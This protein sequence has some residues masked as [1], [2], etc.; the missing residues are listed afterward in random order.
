MSDRDHLGGGQ[1]RF[2]QPDYRIRASLLI[3]PLLASLVLGGPQIRAVGRP[4]PIGIAVYRVRSR[5]DPLRLPERLQPEFRYSGPR[6]PNRARYVLRESESQIDRAE[7]VR[8]KLE[9]QLGIGCGGANRRVHDGDASAVCDPRPLGHR[10]PSNRRRRFHQCCF[11]HGLRSS[12]AQ[13]RRSSSAN[14]GAKASCL[15][16]FASMAFPN[17][18]VDIH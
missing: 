17:T 11:R 7:N 12:I 1:D 8:L 13:R 2:E 9:C 15:N 5:A 14:H 3:P 18:A 6:H 16:V 10:M 4:R